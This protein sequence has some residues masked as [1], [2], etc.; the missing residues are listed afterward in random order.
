LEG[1]DGFACARDYQLFGPGPKRILAL[2]GGGFRN[3]ITIAFLERIEALIFNRL[4]KAVALCDHFHLV[5]GNSSAAIIAGALA[6]GFR[7]EEIRTIFTRLAP[8]AFRRRSWS[9][10]VLQ[11]KFEVRGLRGEMEKVVGDLEL[12]SER[13]R[14]GLAIIT[15]RIDTGSPWIV[16]NNPAAAYWEAGDSFAGN[17]SYKLAN[18]IRA[19][20]SSPRLFDPELLPVTGRT[21]QLSARDAQPMDTPFA[22]RLFQAA[23]KQIGLRR[24]AP[25]DMTSYGLFM[26]ASLTPHSNPSLAFL[27]MVLAKAFNV[28]WTP[29][30]DHLS[31]ISIGTG[32]YAIRLGSENTTSSWEGVASL[33]AGNPRRGIEMLQS[34]ITDLESDVLTQMQYL[35]AC[36][37]PWR[38]HADA[39]PFED[40]P[41]GGKVCRFTHYDVE[42]EPAWLE[43]NLGLKYSQAQITRLQS[44]DDPTV[45]PELYEIGRVA[46]ERQIEAEDL[47]FTTEFP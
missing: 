1:P 22:V 5:G 34:L 42:L 18:L 3:A 2:G 39:D 36:R 41:P 12:Q 31:V 37:T 27:Q 23:L 24:A 30:P 7:C 17:K 9:V 26:D 44:T 38:T 25:L 13:L 33:W 29:G 16:S 32:R 8:L 14:T 35:G 21:G 4:G 28:R 19:S 46:A 20:L 43:A 47:F 40:G 6:L 15:K 11:P 45:V 10:P